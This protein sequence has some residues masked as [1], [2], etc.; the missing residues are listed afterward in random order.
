MFKSRDLLIVAALIVGVFCGIYRSEIAGWA[1]PVIEPIDYYVDAPVREAEM[2]ASIDS[3]TRKVGELNSAVSERG[4][5]LLHAY[6]LMEAQE[7]MARDSRAKYLE[8]ARRVRE[9]GLEADVD[10]DV[11][12]FE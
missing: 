7:L 12:S 4:N 5:E 9:L 10:L 2:K 6:R 3:L 8:Y 11:V 1:N